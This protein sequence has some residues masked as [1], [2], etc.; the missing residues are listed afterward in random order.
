MQI[1]R[2]IQHTLQFQVEGQGQASKRKEFP[3]VKMALRSATNDF[4]NFIDPIKCVAKG[5]EWL[6]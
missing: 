1:K 6:L 5:P 4:K 2:K 3:I